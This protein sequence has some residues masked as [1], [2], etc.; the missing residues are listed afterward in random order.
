MKIQGDLERKVWERE[1]REH[2]EQK[3]TGKNR[4]PGRCGKH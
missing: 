4:N 1:R 2:M 3:T